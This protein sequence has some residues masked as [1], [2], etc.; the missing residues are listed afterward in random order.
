MAIDTLNEPHYPSKWSVALVFSVILLLIIGV[1][2]WAFYVNL[3]T[4]IV[5]GDQSFSVKVNG[6]LHQ[7]AEGSCEISL[8][9]G[10]YDFTAQSDGYYEESFSLLVERWAEVNYPLRFVLVPFLE[11]LAESDLPDQDKL[12]VRVNR[13]NGTIQFIR[14]DAGVEN[15]VT[16]FETLSDPQVRL[17]G[18]QALIVDKGRLFFVDL[19]SG[20]KQRR[21]DN[22][23]FVSDALVSDNG[24]RAL[25]F[26]SMEGADLIL[27]WFNQTSEMMPLQWYEKPEF[28]QWE[29][30]VDH[31]VY[32]ISDQL[33]EKNNPSLFADLL[34]ST[35]LAEPEKSLFQVNV[36]TDEVKSIYTF[37]ELKKPVRLMLRDERYFVE[38]EEGNVEELVVR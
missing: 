10:F 18:N 4:V 15:I 17:G 38:Y 14:E 2:V 9:P 37:S 25:L 23:V 7:C 31:R 20:R 28:V 13:T 19:E 36:D 5:S 3:G 27:L 12:P 22:T 24:K 32:V 11:E 6:D 21:F 33:Q 26:V 29:R 34:Q 8:P 35:N 16:E 30:G 1:F